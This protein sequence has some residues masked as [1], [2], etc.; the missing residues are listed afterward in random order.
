MFQPSAAPAVKTP[1]YRLMERPV[2]LLS[3]PEKAFLYAKLHRRYL[4]KRCQQAQLAFKIHN[5]KKRMARIERD[6]Q[7]WTARRYY[8]GLQLAILDQLPASP[9]PLSPL[10]ASFYTQKQRRLERHAQK[11]RIQM[12][13]NEIRLIDLERRKQRSNVAKLI[14]WES[15]LEALTQSI[16]VLEAKLSTLSP[17]SSEQA[18]VVKTSSSPTVCMAAYPEA[19]IWADTSRNEARL[20]EGMVRR[21]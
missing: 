13:N 19:A 10:E 20:D 8:L 4:T 6:E 2:T 14:L 5:L 11:L 18:A 12:S 7:A 16:E 9:S 15:Q 3:E 17:A 1:I 21:I